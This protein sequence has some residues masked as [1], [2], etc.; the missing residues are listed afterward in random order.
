MDPLEV[1]EP[2]EGEPFLLYE[3]SRAFLDGDSSGIQQR[4]QYRRD[5]FD[6]LAM[7]GI[8]AGGLLLLVNIAQVV[9]GGG[10]AAAGA[11]S[12]T[13]LS[14]LLLSGLLIAGGMYYVT[15]RQNAAAARGRLV[16]EGQVL[17][18]TVVTS[19]AREETT[20]DGSLGHFT[21]SYLVKVEYRFTAPAGHEITDHDEHDR[22]DRRGTDLPAA[23]A[24]VRVLYLNDWTYVLL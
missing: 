12:T 5:F 1:P 4:F 24:S 11:D 23:G 6:Y 22:P 18:G 9:R 17:T 13:M 20:A 19:A 21:R 10:A 2:E 8:A 14:A 15:S 16:R 7:A 3:S